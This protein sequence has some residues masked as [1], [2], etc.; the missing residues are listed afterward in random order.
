MRSGIH[1]EGHVGCSA[2]HLGHGLT[3]VSYVAHIF[4]LADG[5]F[6]NPQHAFEQALV[7]LHDVERLLP[8]RPSRENF[9]GHR[10]WPVEQKDPVRGDRQQG[11]P[12]RPASRR[13]HAARA[14]STDDPPPPH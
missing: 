7:Q 5:F 10:F 3:E 11:V 6:R 13:M 4:L 12:M 2:S 8:Q 14:A 9:A 1:K